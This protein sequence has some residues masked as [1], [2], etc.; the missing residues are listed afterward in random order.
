[1]S[2]TIKDYLDKS[3][4]IIGKT[5]KFPGNEKIGHYLEYQILDLHI[6]EHSKLESMN[7]KITKSNVPGFVK[8]EAS[9]FLFTHLSNVEVKY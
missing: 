4:S 3:E 9:F 7:I 6:D 5:F 1:M 2:K 8:F